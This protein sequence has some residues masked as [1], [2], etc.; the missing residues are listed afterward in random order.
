LL[1]AVRVKDGHEEVEWQQLRTFLRE[2]KPNEKR[3]L[4]AVRI[5]LNTLFV[6]IESAALFWVAI[7]PIAA[8]VLVSVAKRLLHGVTIALAPQ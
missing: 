2:P 4:T 5:G 8:W 1:V 3:F 7:V 6:T